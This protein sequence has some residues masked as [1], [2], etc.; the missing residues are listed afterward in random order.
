MTR[1]RLSTPPARMVPGSLLKSAVLGFVVSLLVGNCGSVVAATASSPTNK[2]LTGSAAITALGGSLPDLAATYGMTAAQLTEKL[3]HDPTLNV[4]P[5]GRLIYL[6][7]AVHNPPSAPSRLMAKSSLATFASPDVDVFSLHS[8]PGSKKVVYLNFQGGTVT[9]P[10]ANL[11]TT[12]PPF[13]TDGD[14]TTF[15]ATEQQQIQEI[16]QRVAEDFAPFDIDVTTQ[17]PSQDALARYNAA[18]DTYGVEVFITK[19]VLGYG[20][21]GQAP[22]GTFDSILSTDMTYAMF[23]YNDS[24]YVYSDNLGYDIPTIA[25]SVSHEVGHT[26][27]LHHQSWLSPAG[28]YYEY[29]PGDGRT[30][31]VPIMSQIQGNRKLFTWYNGSFLGATN[32][33]D[34]IAVM[35]H[36]D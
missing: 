15:G 5:D 2:Y 29:W 9:F 26:L 7:Q 1:R 20:V 33:E 30:N 21:G 36:T 27:G 17:K 10:P 35:Q 34:A 22:I 31:F 13:D 24:A 6:E 4:T 11:S 14:P 32:T 3:Q 25:M 23:E 18:D 12:Y 8:R 16:F 28:N 19:D